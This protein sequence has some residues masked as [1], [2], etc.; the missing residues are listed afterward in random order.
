MVVDVVSGR[1]HHSRSWTS[2]RVCRVRGIP[3]WTKYFPE[4]YPTPLTLEM[5]RRQYHRWTTS[6]HCSLFHLCLPTRCHVEA[7][8]GISWEYKLNSFALLYRLREGTHER[9]S[10]PRLP[11]NISLTRVNQQRRGVSGNSTPV[12]YPPSGGG[13]GTGFPPRP[14]S[15]GPPGYGGPSSSSTPFRPAS[16]ASQYSESPFGG[17]M[18]SGAGA[19]YGHELES[20]NDDL[21]SG[22]LGK[23]DTLKNVSG[24]GSEGAGR[25]G[26]ARGWRS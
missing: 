25:S 23:V 10:K 1:E 21:L 26:G 20:H 5:I 6:R 15:A 16:A 2:T 22:L 17:G 24:L 13:P 18:S 12:L 11:P 3:R 8:A 9:V 4:T 7:Q 14:Q 19:S